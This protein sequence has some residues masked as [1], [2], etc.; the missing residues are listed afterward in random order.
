MS[1]R[2]RI[3]EPGRGRRRRRR[4]WPRPVGFVLLVAGIGIA[5]LL[6][7]MSSRASGPATVHATT[8]PVAPRAAHRPA[9]RTDYGIKLAPAREQV[10]LN[11]K[12]LRSG[13]L[14]DVHTGA[15]LWER[16]PGRELPIASLT[17]MMTALVTVAHSEPTDRVLITREATRFTGSGVGLLPR[18][19]HVLERALLYGLL[20]PSGN[21][22]AVALSQHVAGT[23]AG[24]VAKM[25]AQAHA[26]GLSCTHFSTVS[27]VVDQGNH[28]CASDLALLARAVLANHLL[29]KIVAS[30]SAILPFP[31]KG[32]KLYLY[33]NNP[34]LLT[35]Y[36]GANGV[37][38]GYTSASGPCLVATAQRGRAWLGVVLLHSIN[39]TGQA[40]QL[41]NAGFA[42]LRS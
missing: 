4:R 29:A 6:V 10:R 17:K 24:F 35:R 8:N 9:P 32:G 25:N 41:L 20:L 26:M 16:S 7:L 39:T 30:R 12:H 11:P 15:V 34:L 19:K 38:T 37:K 27:G 31:I 40:E 23:Q 5:A 14:F 36:P 21:D 3:L 42:K 18:G 13:L 22:A 1:Q 2:L 33:N 28:S